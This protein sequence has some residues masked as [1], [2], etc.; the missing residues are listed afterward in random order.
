M[1]CTSKSLSSFWGGIS[2]AGGYLFYTVVLESIIHHVC[3][4]EGEAY[5]KGC[6]FCAVRSEMGIKDYV[7]KAWLRFRMCDI[8]SCISQMLDIFAI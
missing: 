1:I 8:L 3:Y 4:L 5:Y 2:L 7:N 6:F